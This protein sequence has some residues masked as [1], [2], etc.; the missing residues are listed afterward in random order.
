MESF[1]KIRSV[2]TGTGLCCCGSQIVVCSENRH[3]LSC[4]KLKCVCVAPQGTR[5]RQ[6]DGRVPQAEAEASGTEA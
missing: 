5:G 4:I 2:Q 3:L 6:G 1:D